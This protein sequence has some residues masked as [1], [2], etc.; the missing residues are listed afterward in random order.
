[1]NLS[2]KLEVGLGIGYV[3]FGSLVIK[4][5]K[6]WKDFR[7]TPNLSKAKHKPQK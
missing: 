3:T 1:M 7:S 6:N 4:T 2:L 5:M